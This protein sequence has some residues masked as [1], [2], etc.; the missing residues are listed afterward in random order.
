MRLKMRS[1]T[2]C[3]SISSK[4]RLNFVGQCTLFQEKVCVLFLRQRRSFRDFPRERWDTPLIFYR[5]IVT[6]FSLFSP[7]CR[8]L[9][10]N[11]S[12]LGLK[13]SRS[14]C[15][16]GWRRVPDLVGGVGARTMKEHGWK[17]TRE[18]QDKKIIRQE[19]SDKQEGAKGADEVADSLEL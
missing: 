3:S 6:S 9:T 18:E 13:W 12:S 2:L 11:G 19:Q 17:S 10:F 5:R 8:A 16:R 15:C 7:Y 1:A 4:R 14:V